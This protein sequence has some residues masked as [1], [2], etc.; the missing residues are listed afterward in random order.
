MRN[1]FKETIVVEGR[2]RDFSFYSSCQT[3]S[4]ASIKDH[5]YELKHED[6]TAGQ[7]KAFVNAATNGSN[8]EDKSN[9]WYS[10]VLI[11]MYDTEDFFF[12]SKR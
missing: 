10:F 7:R 9:C 5:I 12:K 3:L 8:Y 4:K 1:K 6:C 11:T 2:R